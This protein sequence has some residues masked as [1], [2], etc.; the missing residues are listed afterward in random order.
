LA[1]RGIAAPFETYA[2]Q[3]VAVTGEIVLGADGRPDPERSD[4]TWRDVEP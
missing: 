4:F 3:P 1:R 2:R